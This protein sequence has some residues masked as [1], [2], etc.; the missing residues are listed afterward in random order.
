MTQFIVETVCA[1]FSHCFVEAAT[2]E[3]ARLKFIEGD[4]TGYEV[5]S[6]QDEEIN[7]IKEVK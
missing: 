5:V 1:E 4:Y 3:E 7:S 2:K 6:H